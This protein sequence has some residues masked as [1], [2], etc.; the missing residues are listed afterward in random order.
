MSKY[1]VV[2]KTVKAPEKLSVRR[3]QSS[4]TRRGYV[5]LT[6]VANIAKGIIG[7][8][9]ISAL[10]VARGDVAQHVASN[11][12][13]DHQLEPI[14]DAA[15]RT[16]TFWGAAGAGCA[17]FLIGVG[18]AALASLCFCGLIKRRDPAPAGDSYELAH[19][20]RQ[21]ARAEWHRKER[22]GKVDYSSVEDC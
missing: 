14:Y 4:P 19:F 15:N 2:R 11:G 5:G 7:A 6:R 16:V 17:A 12:D 18:C 1:R 3:A 21:L 10:K 22:L 9:L 13:P 8:A 20:G